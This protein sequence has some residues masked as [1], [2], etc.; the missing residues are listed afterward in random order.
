MRALSTKSV[1]VVA[2]LAGASVSGWAKVSAQQGS[3]PAELAAQA[4][5]HVQPVALYPT[6]FAGP[7]PTATQVEAATPVMGP[8]QE[9]ANMGM[10]VLVGLGMLGTLMVKSRRS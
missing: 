6:P 3:Q 4:Q 8:D 2:V 5:P 7:Q 10:V 9:Q 1:V